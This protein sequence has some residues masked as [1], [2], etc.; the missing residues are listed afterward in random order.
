LLIIILAAF[1]IPII[2]V[3]EQQ[4]NWAIAMLPLALPYSILSEIRDEIIQVIR[5]GDS[6]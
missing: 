5:E 6:Q 3:A 4:L 1:N 2:V